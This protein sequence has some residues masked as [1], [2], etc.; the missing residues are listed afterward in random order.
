MVLEGSLPEHYHNKPSGE[1]LAFSQMKTFP[2]PTGP[3]RLCPLY[4]PAGSLSSP[5][6]YPGLVRG[7]GNY[8]PGV[9]PLPLGL[10]YGGG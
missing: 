6:E 5:A 10:G 2:D 8:S 7:K 3:L 1:T 4:P 9:P